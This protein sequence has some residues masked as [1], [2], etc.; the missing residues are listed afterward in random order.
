MILIAS[1]AGVIGGSSSIA[2]GASKGAVN[3]MG[4][5]LE[6]HL[7]RRGI[8]VNVVCPGG[9]ETEMK[10]SVIKT[11]AEREGQSYEA[12]VAASHLGQPIG[13]ARLLAYLASD[14]ADYVRRNLFTR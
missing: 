1:G 4:M 13:V 5:T 6:G 12:L 9:I 3:G 7:A 11:Q 10:L 14:E 8:R 2:Y